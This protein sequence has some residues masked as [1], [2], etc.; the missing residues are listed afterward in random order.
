MKLQ[1]R[2][3]AKGQR[4]ANPDPRLAIYVDCK[5]WNCLPQAGGWYDQDPEICE[6]FTVIENEINRTNNEEQRQQAM[7]RK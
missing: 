5:T 3:F 6:A 7:R 1:A 4:I 2:R